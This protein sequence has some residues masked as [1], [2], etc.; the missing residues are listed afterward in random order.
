V[1]VSD[2]LLCLPV[3]TSLACALSRRP[4]R[5]YITNG[6]EISCGCNT[7]IHS[8]DLF[9]SLSAQTAPITH[10]GWDKYRLCVGSAEYS[11]G[12]LFVA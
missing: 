10:A 2:L 12:P 7:L 6:R 5:G 4:P 3:A 11:L 1:S 9:L 8:S